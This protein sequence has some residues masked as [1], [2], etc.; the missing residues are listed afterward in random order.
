[1]GIP[2][3]QYDKEIIRRTKEL[4]ESYEGEYKITLF[5]NSLLSLIVLP[6]E[7]SKERNMKFL[8]ELITEVDVIRNIISKNGFIFKEGVTNEKGKPSVPNPRNLDN[9]LRKIRNGISHQHITPVSSALNKWTGV[10]FKDYDSN[11]TQG[12]H[13]EFTIAELKIFA[14]YIANSYLAEK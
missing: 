9:L 12:L 14:L 5:M 10:I 6:K 8:K 3:G 1:M 4:I 2:L 7:Y 13:I 11:H